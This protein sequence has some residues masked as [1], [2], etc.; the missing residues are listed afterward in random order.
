[1]EF[2]RKDPIFKR[3][4]CVAPRGH[5]REHHN[6][7]EVMVIISRTVKPV[8]EKIPERTYDAL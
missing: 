6:S 8:M 5:I 4:S 1:M 7:P 3:R 2:L